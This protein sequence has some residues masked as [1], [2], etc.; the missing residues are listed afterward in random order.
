[1]KKGDRVMTKY[2]QG[3]IINREGNE[4]I[5]KERFCV[6]VDCLKSETLQETQ[7]THGGIYIFQSDLKP[8]N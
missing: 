3:T 8:I 4:G 1:M 5:L 6:K 2:G 7:N